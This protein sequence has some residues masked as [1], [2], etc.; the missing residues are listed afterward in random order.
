MFTLDNGYM[1]LLLG[2]GVL[3]F[4]VFVIGEL[5]LVFQAY[6]IEKWMLLIILILYLMFGMMETGLIRPHCNFFLLLLS[7]VLWEGS[8][9][10]DL[11]KKEKNREY[12]ADRT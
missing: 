5:L 4:S 3:A 9:I 7:E 12:F 11:H 10:K 2:F 8:S 1:Y 6:R